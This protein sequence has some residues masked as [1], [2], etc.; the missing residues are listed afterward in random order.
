MNS[1]YEAVELFD[2][3]H[4]R[5]WWHRIGARVAG[6][7]VRL[8]DLSAIVTG[9][10]TGQ[11]HSFGTQSVSIQH[12]RGSE[13]QHE[14]FDDAFHPLHK[15]TRHRWQAIAAAWLEG[16]SLPPVE[17]I[18]VGDVYFVR[19]GHHRISVVQALGIAEIDAVVVA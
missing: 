3:A 12:I 7:P 2:R 5:G 8:L 19:D 10:M 6:R 1:L 16:V 13:G 18:Q 11:R 9:N 4:R 17:L 15:R 14:M